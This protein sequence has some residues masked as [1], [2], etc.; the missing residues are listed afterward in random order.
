MMHVF[1]A[2]E[3]A[4][5]LIAAAPTATALGLVSGFTHPSH[6]QG[7]ARSKV[8]FVGDVRRGTKRERDR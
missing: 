3:Y 5:L 1:V 6:T 8:V 7:T 2:E 4:R